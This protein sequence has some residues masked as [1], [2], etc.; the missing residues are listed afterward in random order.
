MLLS[1]SR[2]IAQARR[3]R[4]MWGGGMRQVGLLAAA[5]DY[6]VDNHWS[7]MENDHKKA[8]IFCRS[9]L[10]KCSKLAINLEAIESNIVMFDVKSGNADQAV[11]LLERKGIFMVSFGPKT[12]RATFHFQIT[13]DHLKEIVSITKSL[14]G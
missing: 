6:A 12:I 11:E 7:L 9:S 10:S 1:T 8:Q 13:D 3:Y 14:F 5:A 4:K 2:R